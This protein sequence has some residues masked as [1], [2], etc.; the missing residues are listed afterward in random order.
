M[1]TEPTFARLVGVCRLH[2]APVD[3]APAITSKRIICSLYSLDKSGL[4][5][6]W[7]KNHLLMLHIGVPPGETAS[8]RRDSERAFAH[9]QAGAARAPHEA[10]DRMYKQTVPR[11]TAVRPR[12]PHCEADGCLLAY[13]G[14]VA[15]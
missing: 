11:R 10:L 6:D 3:F 5:H 9:H 8:E 2:V 1:S 4:A 13:V 15:A 7:P 12:P 14:L